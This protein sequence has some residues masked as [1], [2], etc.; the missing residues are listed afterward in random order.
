[1][2]RSSRIPSLLV[3]SLLAL[4]AVACGRK[5]A[6]VDAEPDV[7]SDVVHTDATASEDTAPMDAGPPITPA[8]RIVALGTWVPIRQEPRRDGGLVGYMRAGAITAVEGM[9]V[10]R[11][12]CPVRREYPEGGWYRLPSGGYVCVGSALSVPWPARG[13]QRPVQPMLDAGMPYEYAK[14]YSRVNIWRAPPSL[15]DQRTHEPWRFRRDEDRAAAAEASE[16]ETPAPSSARRDRNA[17]SAGASASAEATPSGEPRLRD[18]KGERGGPV[19]RRML[20]GMYVALDRQVRNSADGER[21]WRTQSG[22]YVRH[23]PLSM[24]RTAPTFQGVELDDNRTLPYAFMV[25][26]QGWSY[27]VTANGRGVSS[28]RQVP[29]FTAIQLANEE[30]LEIGGQRYWRTVD[31]LAVNERSVR[32][33]T[34]RTPPADSTPTE[35]WMDVDLD[36]QV[37]VAYEGPR[38]VYVT[39]V[40]TGRRSETDPNRNWET[41]AG[42]FRIR[43]KHIS[44]TMDGDTAADGPYSIEDVPWAMYFL[45]SYA[46]HAAFWHNNFGSRMSHGCVNLSPPDARWL[47]WWADPQLP[48]GWHGVFAGP[49]RPGSRLEIH[50]HNQPTPRTPR[51][52]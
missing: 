1:V 2:S 27:R 45:D 41:P 17:R 31:G 23:S 3:L 25:S 28:H 37:I 33:A 52:R 42:A 47:F 12:T 30:P 20:A 46:M 34:L 50:R 40:S 16:S 22:G 32:V 10:G 13:V 6:A 8:T 36:Q 18:L 15:E 49:D 48:E 51:W 44:T 4:C 14:V 38:P 7:L 21:Y 24:L 26:Q 5:P 11:E 19:V 29:R 39:L 9:P 35:R 43:G